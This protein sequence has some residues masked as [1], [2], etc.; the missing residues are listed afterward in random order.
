MHFCVAR[1]KQVPFGGGAAQRSEQNWFG[2]VHGFPGPHASAVHC[3]ST[4]LKQ[5][6]LGVPTQSARQLCIAARHAAF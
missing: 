6:P 2:C 5:V 3:M 4:V 1:S